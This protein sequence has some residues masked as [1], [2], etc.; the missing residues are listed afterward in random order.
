MFTSEAKKDSELNPTEQT[1]AGLERMEKEA[2]E[3]EK[4][5]KILPYSESYKILYDKRSRYMDDL[6]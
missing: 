4:N 1:T 6:K 5:F 3:I 2:R